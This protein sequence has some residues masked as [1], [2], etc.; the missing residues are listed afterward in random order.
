[1]SFACYLYALIF[2][3]CVLNM[4]S[5]CHSYVLACH[6]CVASM[7]SYV[8]RMYSYVIRVSFVC[9]RMLSVLFVGNK[10]KGEPQNGYFK[11]RKH[12]RFSKNEHFLPPD[13]TNKRRLGK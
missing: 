8:I 4:P 11:K 3:L 7:Y 12:V 5:V 6:L 9:T 10:A 1:M 2:Y 13:T